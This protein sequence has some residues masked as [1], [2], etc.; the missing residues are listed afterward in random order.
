MNKSTLIYWISTILFSAF[1]LF[2]AYQYLTDPAMVDAFKY[3]GYPDH[4]RV[5]L[6]IAKLLG[7]IILLLPFLPQVVRGFTYAG[8]TINLLGALIAHLAMNEPFSSL[9]LVFIVAIPLALSYFFQ[10]KKLH[11]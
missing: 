11:K 3:L 7:A 4:F 6:G 5:E 2:N 9:I 8:F 1:M 10:P